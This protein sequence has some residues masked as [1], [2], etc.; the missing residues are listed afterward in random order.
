M[1]NIKFYIQT[2][3]FVYKVCSS[4]IIVVISLG[5]GVIGL[6]VSLSVE[7]SSNSHLQILVNSSYNSYIYG[8]LTLSLTVTCCC[9]F[10]CLAP[11]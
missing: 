4:A 6:C 1:Y 2:Y 7:L 3:M 11:A 8:S 5:T 10:N 9:L